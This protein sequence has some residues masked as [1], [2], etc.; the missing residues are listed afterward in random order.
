[1]QRIK[2]HNKAQKLHNVKIKVKKHVY[3]YEQNRYMEFVA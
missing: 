1:M 2:N 3:E